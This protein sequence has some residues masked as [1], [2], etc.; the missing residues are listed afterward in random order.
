MEKGHFGEYT[1]N[2]RCCK[3]SADLTILKKLI[4]RV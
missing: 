1:G 4:T 3:G 2:A